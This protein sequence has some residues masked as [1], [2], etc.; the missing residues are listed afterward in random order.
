MNGATRPNP[1]AFGLFIDFHFVPWSRSRN[2]KPNPKLSNRSLNWKVT[3]L[4]APHSIETKYRVL[5]VDYQAG[6]AHCPSYQPNARPTIDYAEKIA[7]ETE[8][9]RRF[10]GALGGGAPIRPD[11]VAVVG[12]LLSDAD[13]LNYS[14]FEDWAASLGYDAD[15]RKAETTYRECLRIGLALRNAL[16]EAKLAQLRDAYAEW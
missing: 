13:A 5:D 7:F 16:G 9:G 14:S 12:C 2:A 10:R 3:L 6:I 4:H 11:P 8:Q 15:S 1:Q